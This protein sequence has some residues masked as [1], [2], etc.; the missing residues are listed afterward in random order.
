MRAILG[1]RSQPLESTVIVELDRNRQRTMKKSLL[2]K[3]DLRAKEDLVVLV[4][5]IRSQSRL[6]TEFS[7]EEGHLEMLLKAHKRD[8]CSLDKSLQIIGA[9]SQNINLIDLKGEICLNKKQ[10]STFHMEE[11]TTIIGVDPIRCSRLV[12][13]PVRVMLGMEWSLAS[14]RIEKSLDK[15]D[16]VRIQAGFNSNKDQL[17]Q[18]KE[19]TETWRMLEEGKAII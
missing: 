8:L 11:E 9:Q 4:Q 16:S 15:S 2:D 18:T 3:E 13:I 5:E 14:S 10:G 17:L 1:T 7:R 19:L 12:L 6:M